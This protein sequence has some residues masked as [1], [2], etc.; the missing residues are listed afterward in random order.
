LDGSEQAGAWVEPYAATRDDVRLALVAGLQT[1]PPTQRAVW[2]LREVL[3][4]PAAE[5]GE[6]LDLSAAAV[7]SSLQRARAQLK[8][9]ELQP[10]DIVEPDAA[11]ARRFLDAYVTAFQNAE[12]DV[13]IE[14]LRADIKLEILPGRR[15]YD[16]LVECVPVFRAA[17]GDSGDWRMTPTIANGQPAAI[18]YLNGA[19]YGL[20]VLD[21]R[22]N[23]IAAVTVFDDPDLV[24]RFR[25]TL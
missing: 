1:L 21:V 24:E 10:D 15:W 7:K 16:G 18:A 4:F 23:G 20:A 11:E 19:P 14:V 17:M 9:A 25:R 6:M 12:V 2:L 22:L 13:L 5:V 8:D 3:A